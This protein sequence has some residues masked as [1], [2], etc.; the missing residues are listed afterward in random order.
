MKYKITELDKLVEQL[1]S[2][3]R[4]LFK[5]FYSFDTSTGSLKIP[6][7]MEDWV[8]K[9]F[10]SVER[11]EK[12]RIVTIKNKFTGE[13]S[14]FNE[15]RSDRPVEAKSKIKLEE[16]EEKENCLFCNPEKQTPT[17][18]F[19]RVKGKYC[20]TGSNIAKYDSFHSLIIFDEHNPLVIKREW[21]EDYLRTAERWLEEV[22]KCEG[23]KNLQK[24][25]LW[26][27]LWRSG[28]SIIHGHIQ[29]TASRMRYGKLE[30][31]EKVA[32]DYKREFNTD[33]IED[34][35]KVHKSLGLV[36][37]NEGE[38]ILFYLTPVK[39]K[40]IFVISKARR[41]D[42]MADT[43]YKLVSNYLA[44]GVQSFNLAIFQL[45]DHHIAR[46][47]DRGSLDDRNSDIGAM[48][49]YAASVISSD[50]FKLVQVI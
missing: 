11:V 15:L 8:K 50:P 45:H 23:E 28:A 4:E 49:L 42:E 44:L 37:E 26:N 5:R 2:D 48:E 40:E 7:E 27:C 38:R 21:I 33:Y 34:L 22:T 43:I 39:E 1:S 16:L 12:Q 14:L 13:H 6:V 36:K 24:F 31:L 29:L 20:I 18:V 19:G 30:V 32:A 46:L 25:F 10:G 9:R 35:Y 41:S 3:V 47:V 17:D